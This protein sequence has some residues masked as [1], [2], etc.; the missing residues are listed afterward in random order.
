MKSP[1]CPNCGYTIKRTIGCVIQGDV[2]YYLNTEH[3]GSVYPKGNIWDFWKFRKPDLIAY[4]CR[5]CRKYFPQSMYVQIR[6]YIKQEHI[7]NRLT[8]QSKE[9]FT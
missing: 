5:S 6:K 1:K 9:M 3:C 8:G 2:T 7:L 4:Y